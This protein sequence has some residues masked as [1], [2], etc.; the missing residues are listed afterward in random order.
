MGL[1]HPSGMGSP[2]RGENGTPRDAP[3]D[4]PRDTSNDTPGAPPRKVSIALTLRQTWHIARP[5]W[6]SSERGRALML[7]AAAVGL[8]LG[9]VALAVKINSINSGL[10]DALQNYDASGFIKNLMW[11]GGIAAIYIGFAMYRY[12]LQQLLAIRWRRW[13]SHYYLDR[14]LTRRAY[15]HMQLGGRTADNPDQRLAD[16]AHQ[17]VGYFLSLTLG[18]IDSVV[19]L[20]S[21]LVVLWQLSGALTLDLSGI[22]V[23]TSLVIPGYLVY[24][25]VI[26]A[27]FGTWA[28]IALGRPLVALNFHQ[29]R[30]EADLRFGLIR[31]REA[32]EQIA[33]LRGEAQENHGLRQR[34]AHILEVAWLMARRRKLLILLTSGYG[35]VASIFPLVVVAPRFFERTI[36]LG[37]MMQTVGAFN[38]VQSALS[39]MV[40]VYP[41]FADF[42]AVTLRLIGFE[43]T[44]NAQ[45]ALPTQA[46]LPAQADMPAQASFPTQAEMPRRKLHHYY[47]NR[48]GVETDQLQIF[49]PQGA[50]ILPPI[51][52]ALALGDSLLI[53]GRSGL[54]KSSLLRCLA[55]IWPYAAG[56]ITTPDSEQMVFLPQK[57]YLP[58]GSLR[59]VLCYPH[60]PE[61]FPSGHIEEIMHACG[62]A[63]WCD[64][65]EVER[66]WASIL[67]LGEC[68]RIGLARVLLSKPQLALLDEAT[69]SLDFDSEATLYR[70]LRLYV[71]GI[72]VLSVGHHASLPEFH[73]RTLNLEDL[74]SRPSPANISLNP[75]L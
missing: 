57:P 15:Y 36:G 23:A 56:R 58:I 74:R 22:G 48:I 53:T 43:Q 44:I 11:F 52:L 17:F 38:Q 12:Y 13:L 59:A 68:Q 62:L 37:A 33:L 28:T 55:G 65:L 45:A 5:F 2:G 46:A 24:V 8:N 27:G 47:D 54:G 16:D 18:T 31:L 26:Y 41:N 51:N 69:A 39:Y 71:P 73:Q 1:S 14:Y 25:A 66:N 61:A 34:I 40:D 63:A 4:A 29:Q 67:S 20:F 70:A 60:P 35:Q 19:T 21:F 49:T 3:R 30:L 42:Q 72:T 50:A 32:A 7:L 10:F 9:I 6:Y 64:Q 75:S